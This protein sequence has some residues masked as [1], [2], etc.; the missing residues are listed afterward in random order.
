MLDL[1]DYNNFCLFN[2]LSVIGSG[3]VSGGN[4]VARF[5]K[6]ENSP[7]PN[8]V[9]DV[10]RLDKDE[11]FFNTLRNLIEENNLQPLVF[12]DAEAVDPIAFKNHKFLP[13]DR[14]VKMQ[15]DLD[16]YEPRVG[17][18]DFVST[19]VTDYN[20]L[21]DWLEIVSKTL[22]NDKKLDISLLKWMLER[23]EFKFQLGTYN[24]I[25]VC[26]SL[27]YT[28]KNNIAGIYMVSTLPDRKSVV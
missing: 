24:N 10:R 16:S 26:A 21:R 28:D 11:V 6:H 18:D 1:C 12:C 4:E 5:V 14:W 20:S 19:V 7:W 17:I 13:V 27:T 23:P 22:F 15:L 3:V 8:V 2:Q 25:P 9:Y